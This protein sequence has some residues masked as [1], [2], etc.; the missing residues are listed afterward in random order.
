MTSISA[1]TTTDFSFFTRSFDQIF[2]YIF[3]LI[4]VNDLTSVFRFTSTL[5]LT[6]THWFIFSS[7]FTSTLRFD[8]PILFLLFTPLFACLFT[9]FFVWVWC[10]SIFRIFQDCWVLVSTNWAIFNDKLR[11][12]TIERLDFIW[13]HVAEFYGSSSGWRF[14]FFMF[15]RFQ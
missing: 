15:F 10:C 11:E 7:R 2:G 13:T 8:W 5:G 9:S 12:R 6:Y 4:L 14:A 1:L 3:F